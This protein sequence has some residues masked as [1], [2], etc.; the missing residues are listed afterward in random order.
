MSRRTDRVAEL[1]RAELAGALRAHVS[2]PRVAL[3]TVTR[4]EVSPDLRNATVFWSR[5]D[6]RNSPPV[7]ETAAGLA[8]A[9][10]YLRRR[11][12]KE[13]P[14]KRVPA[15][16]FRHDPSLALGDQTLAALREL[17]RNGS[18]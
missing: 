16:E 3:V 15:L 2:D 4:V 7:E 11:L 5:M 6:T 10:A 12:A 13:L 8:R 1:I 18:P 14:L 17:N 9:A